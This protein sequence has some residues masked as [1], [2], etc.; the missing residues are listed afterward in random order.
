MADGL[1]DI[2]RPRLLA[3]SDEHI[4]ND[5]CEYKWVKVC[6]DKADA[7]NGATTP[8]VAE[9]EVLGSRLNLRRERKLTRRLCGEFAATIISK[10][11]RYGRQK[12][13]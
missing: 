6:D 9:L 4:K 8:R 11:V 12:I 1:I 3:V 7:A 2:I 13:A 10:N 5:A